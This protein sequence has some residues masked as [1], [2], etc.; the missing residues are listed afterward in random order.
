MMVKPVTCGMCFAIFGD[1]VAYCPVCKA[2]CGGA[3]AEVVWAEVDRLESELA[4]CRRAYDA[5]AGLARALAA[6]DQP[7]Y[8]QL[9]MGAA[10]RLMERSEVEFWV[11]AGRASGPNWLDAAVRYRDRSKAAKGGSAVEVANKLELF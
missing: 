3:S 8:E 7:S 6:F 10:Y 2:R 11:R 1:D 9:M 5:A 4:A